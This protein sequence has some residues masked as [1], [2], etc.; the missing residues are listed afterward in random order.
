MIIQRIKIVYEVLSRRF[1]VSCRNPNLE[2]VNY[3]SPFM[4][5]RDA[6][7]VIIE[8][9]KSV[10]RAGLGLHDLLKTPTVVRISFLSK[11]NNHV[12]LIFKTGNPSPCRTEKRR[13]RRARTR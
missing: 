3:R 10:V 9:T 6:N 7:V 12:E 8:V 4:S 1:P 5:I 11:L 2:V 13:F